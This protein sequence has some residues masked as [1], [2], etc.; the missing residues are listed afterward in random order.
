MSASLVVLAA[1]MGSRY[2]GFKQIDPVGPGGEFILDYSLYDAARAG[3]DQVVFVVRPEIEKAMRERFSAIEDRMRVRYVYQCA[4]DL[5]DAGQ[6]PRVERE[7]PWGTGHAVWSARNAVDGPFAVINADDFY[8]PSAYQLLADFFSSRG[9]AVS[10]TA[11]FAMVAF[12]LARTLSEHGAVS[13]GVC[14]INDDETL[15]GV[16][17]VE[18]IVPDSVG[19]GRAERSDGPPETF[20]GDIPVSM[21][22]WGFTPAVFDILDRLLAEFT[23]QNAFSPRAEFYLPTAIDT[24]RRHEQCQVTVL[25]SQDAWLGM[26]YREDQPRVREGIRQLVKTGTYPDTL[27]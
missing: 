27:R 21:N 26:T 19:G 2:G 12:E 20:A 11:Q 23:R 17:E 13:R 4:D 8:A 3:F 16:R 14:T 1:G 18:K 15:Q 5:P 9:S 25:R 7:K 24:A 6:A 22:F 10:G